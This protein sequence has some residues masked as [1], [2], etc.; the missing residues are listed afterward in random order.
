MYLVGSQKL[1]CFEWPIIQEPTEIALQAANSNSLGRLLDEYCHVLS[2]NRILLASNF[3]FQVW[4][5][6]TTA[7]TG[8][9]EENS[10][11]FHQGT[12]L[13]VPWWKK[14]EISSFILTY[15]AKLVI[16]CTT[17]V[18]NETFLSLSATNWCVVTTTISKCI[19][20]NIDGK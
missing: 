8:S 9:N 6:N 4:E 14:T 13:V 15:S 11:F 17:P 3:S 5:I 12:T 16:Q 19:M 1:I 20:W 2:E 18:K 10:V 7:R